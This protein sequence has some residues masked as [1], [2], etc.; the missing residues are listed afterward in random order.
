MTEDK[1]IKKAKKKVKAQKE[2]YTHVGIYIATI[3]FLFVLNWVTSPSFWWFLIPAAGWGIGIVGHYLDVFGFPHPKGKDW[4][5]E[6]LQKE[7]RKLKAQENPV[8][9]GDRLELEDEMMLK[10]YR[11]DM[12]DYDEEEFV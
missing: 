4:E 10:D 8:E 2:F 1:L 11:M 6:A 5:R 12:P 7:I 3:F 9:D